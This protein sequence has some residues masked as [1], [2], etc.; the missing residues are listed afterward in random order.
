MP[1]TGPQEII[2]NL[3]S[4]RIIRIDSMSR[5]WKSGR[6]A[7]KSGSTRTGRTI[8]TAVRFRIVLMVVMISRLSAAN[9]VLAAVIVPNYFISCQFTIPT[10]SSQVKCQQPRPVI[11]SSLKKN[12]NQYL[13]EEFNSNLVRDK[14]NRAANSS[15]A[16]RSNG[17][18]PLQTRT[19]TLEN[20]WDSDAIPMWTVS[21]SSKDNNGT[22]LVLTSC[23]ELYICS[24]D[25]LSINESFR[26]KYLLCHAW[27]AKEKNSF[28]I[29]A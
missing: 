2:W 16:A 17:A 27:R 22:E 1:I 12:E 21:L 10:L 5:V 9:S 6:F 19:S 4:R 13:K 14:P 20:R 25:V 7:Y 29:K 8:G 26:R 23:C 28:S 15:S 24:I 18:L 3:F 11:Y